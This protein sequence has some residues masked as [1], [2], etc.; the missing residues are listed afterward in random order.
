MALPDGAP[1]EGAGPDH[2]EQC[3]RLL[4]GLL[5]CSAW[6]KW[7]AHQSSYQC[8]EASTGPLCHFSHW[9]GG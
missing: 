6:F 8:T 9:G 4:S 3:V 7:G 1:I 5:K 2:A